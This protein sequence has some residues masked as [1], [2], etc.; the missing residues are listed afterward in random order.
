M[1]PTLWTVV[2]N[3]TGYLPEM[4]PY[5][6]RTPAE[7]KAALI[8]E[9]LQAADSYDS[10]E[11]AGLAEDLNLADVQDGWTGYADGIAWNVQRV[12]GDDYSFDDLFDDERDRL[13]LIVEDGEPDKC[14]RDDC[15]ERAYRYP[16]TSLCIGHGG[17]A[18]QRAVDD[19]TPA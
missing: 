7:A 1:N 6:F 17:E 8:A 18:L 11:L 13:G 2:Y 12:E 9:I 3:S 5:S 15:W 19:I 10:D 14:Y 4:E 16:M